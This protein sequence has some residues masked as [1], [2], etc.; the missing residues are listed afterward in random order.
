MSHAYSISCIPSYGRTMA[1]AGLFFS[2]NVLG[3]IFLSEWNLNVSKKSDAY[4]DIL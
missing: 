1:L 3:G 4:S 2:E